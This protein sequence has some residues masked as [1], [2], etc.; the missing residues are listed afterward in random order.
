MQCYYD[1][2]IYAFNLILTVPYKA[3][4]KI[5]HYDRK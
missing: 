2:Q 5:A 1:K 3:T 4:I